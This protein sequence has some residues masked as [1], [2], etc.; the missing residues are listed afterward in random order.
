M[1]LA[2]IIN[3]D[4]FRRRK[5]P[6]FN[7]RDLAYMMKTAQNY[8]SPFNLGGLSV[9]EF[10]N[11]FWGL[12]AEYTIHE[13]EQF[14]ANNVYFSIT[15]PITLKRFIEKYKELLVANER[16]RETKSFFGSIAGGVYC[17][18]I[19][20]GLVLKRCS[21][22]EETI[23]DYIKEAEDRAKISVGF[24]EKI[25]KNVIEAYS[26][27]RQLLIGFG[28]ELKKLRKEI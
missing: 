25:R 19:I 7:D 9:E 4:D 21:L 3:M 5:N 8:E 17:I 16:D 20:A 12:M 15:S 22:G 23:V 11:L 2:E 24:E 10:H 27:Q 1:E 13:L 6:V 18:H 26:Q 28:D 14:D